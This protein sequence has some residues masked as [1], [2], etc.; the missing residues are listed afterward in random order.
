MMTFNFITTETLNTL[1]LGA[2]ELRLHENKAIHSGGDLAKTIFSNEQ[3][4]R[5]ISNYHEE[6]Q[7]V[8]QKLPRH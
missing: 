5:L 8:I 6:M 7:P 4:G 2:L 3:S 1:W